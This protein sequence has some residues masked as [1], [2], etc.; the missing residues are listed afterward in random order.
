MRDVDLG[1]DFWQRRIDELTKTIANSSIGSWERDQ[2]EE[3]LELAQIRLKHAKKK[4]LRF[5]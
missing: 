3:D 1:I 4:A 5:R 2:A